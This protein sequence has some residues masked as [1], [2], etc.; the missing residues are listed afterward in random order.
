MNEDLDGL[1]ILNTLP[2]RHLREGETTLTGF[3][4]RFELD[5]LY[6]LVQDLMI[7][8]NKSENVKNVD[9]AIAA[10]RMRAPEAHTS[11]VLKIAYR[12]AGYS[13]MEEFSKMVDY[14]KAST[15]MDAAKDDPKKGRKLREKLIEQVTGVKPKSKAQMNREALERASS[16]WS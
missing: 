2:S 10:I 1:G 8:S 5:R 16:L 4:L 6:P 12:I 13:W 14:L 15:A 9:E 7:P 3:E 11:A